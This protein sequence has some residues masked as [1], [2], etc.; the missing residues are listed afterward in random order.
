MH[1]AQGT[2]KC[3]PGGRFTCTFIINEMVFTFSGSF[4]SIVPQFTS[5]NIKLTYNTP[6]HLRSTKSFD[7]R[8]GP[9]DIKITLVDGDVI[10]GVLD[11]P[12]DPGLTVSGSGVW[13]AE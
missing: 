2:I 13:N 11:E 7:G 8:I 9:N 5:A 10:E 1:T 3:N 6:N 12:L 4:I